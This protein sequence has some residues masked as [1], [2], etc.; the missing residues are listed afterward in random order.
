MRIH[1]NLDEVLK[2][3]SKIKILRF[4]FTEKDE[5]TGR[6]IARGVDMSASFTYE[7]LQEMKEENLIS[8]RRK[9]NA[10]LYKL[11]TDNYIIKKMLA[12][13]FEGE[14][15]VYDDIIAIIKRNLIRH[16]KDIVSVAIFGSIIRKEETAKS[17]ID[18]VIVANNETAKSRIEGAIDKLNIDMVKKIGTIISPYILTDI[19]IKRKYAEKKKIIISILNNNQLIY[20]EPI[21]RILA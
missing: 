16:K 19:E 15:A 14:K 17:D 18:L 3:K 2:S 7:T 8:A 12:P 11:Q 13:L 1:D 9:G 5:H 21:E 6:A 10:I 20:G 4:L